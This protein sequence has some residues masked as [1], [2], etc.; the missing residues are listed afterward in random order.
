MLRFSEML[1]PSIFTLFLL[2]DR[3]I[4]ESLLVN[5]D[6]VEFKRVSVTQ[7]VGMS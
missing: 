4:T 7:T 1:I 6:I 2:S 3:L 5:T